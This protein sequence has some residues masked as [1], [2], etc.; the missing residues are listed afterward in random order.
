MGDRAVRRTADNLCVA[1]ERARL[2]VVLTRAPGVAALGQFFVAERDVE[3]AGLG[4]DLDPVT[5]PEQADRPPDCGLGT[6][7]ADAEAARRAGNRPSVMSAT[8]WPSPSP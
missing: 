6:N 4:I 5:V 8:S 3:R 7:M 1:P 2:V